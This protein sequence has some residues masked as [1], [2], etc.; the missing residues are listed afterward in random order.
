MKTLK[1]VIMTQED[2]YQYRNTEICWFC[3]KVV[4]S[5]ETRYHSQ[6]TIE[7]RASAHKKIK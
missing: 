1:N 5:I 6:L 4:N 2:E 7:Y 3:E